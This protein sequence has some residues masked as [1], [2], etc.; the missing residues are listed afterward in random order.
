MPKWLVQTLRDSKLDAPLSSRT[1]FGSQNISYAS[2]C[3]AL[4]VSSLCDEDEPVTFDEA[5]NLENWWAAM[6]SKFDAVMKNGTWS[7]VDLSGGKRPLVAS[8]F[9]S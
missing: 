2:D 7:L 1:R 6:Q 4:A 8:G 3:Y 9:L 5:H